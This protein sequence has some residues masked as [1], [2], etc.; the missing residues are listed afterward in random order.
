M[1]RAKLNSTCSLLLHQLN[2]NSQKANIVG[3]IS[4]GRTESIRE[5]TDEEANNL[6]QYLQAQVTGNEAASRMRRKILAMG[7][8]LHWHL[9]GTQKI[10]MERVNRWCIKY[11]TGHKKL[12]DYTATEL[13]KLVTQFKEVHKDLLETI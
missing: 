13:P 3:G 4:F 5:L 12:N 2:L 1:T 6:R 9:P 7:H 10:D 11:G 8:Q